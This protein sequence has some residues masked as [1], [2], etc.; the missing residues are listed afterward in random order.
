MKEEDQALRLKMID[1][2]GSEYEIQQ[3]LEA[4]DKKLTAELKEIVQTHGWPT[5]RLVGKEASE[6]AALILNHSPDHDFQR[7]WIP[8]LQKLADQDK[9]VGADL[10]LI[11]DKVLLSEGKPQLF[12]NV[13]RFEGNFM[14][15]QP[16]QDREHLD[17]RRARYLLPP[18]K[19]YIKI[20]EELYHKKLKEP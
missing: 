19:E 8:K 14:I 20:M 5:I 11:I 6:S 1:N 16:V 9:I 7:E 18:I 12:G 4:V 17:D 2:P 3:Q 10:A 13:F 15:M